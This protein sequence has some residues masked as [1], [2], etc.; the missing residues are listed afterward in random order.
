MEKRPGQSSQT[1]NV[2]IYE[3]EVHLKFRIIE[4]ELSLDSTDNSALIETL[5]DA[6]SYGEDEYLE[7]LESQINIQEIAALEASPEMRRQLIRL[8]NSRKLA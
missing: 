4:N 2:N 6:Y 1:D 5:V 7:S 3:C 8:R